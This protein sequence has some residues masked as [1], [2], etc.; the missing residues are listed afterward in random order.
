[1]SIIGMGILK[2]SQHKGISEGSRQIAHQV[3]QS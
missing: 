3:I 1:M 2:R